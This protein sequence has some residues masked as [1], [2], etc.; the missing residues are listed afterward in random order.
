[1]YRP[2]CARHERFANRYYGWVVRTGIGSWA[3]WIGVMDVTNH[4]AGPVGTPLASIV[5]PTGMWAVRLMPRSS[6]ALTR[7]R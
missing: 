4:S 5:T 7:W 2:A 3:Y 6:D 1:M